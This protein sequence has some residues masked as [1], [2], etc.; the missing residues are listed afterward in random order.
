MK[1]FLLACVLTLLSFIGLA[2]DKSKIFGKWKVALIFD[3]N[4]FYDVNKD[5]IG[6][7]STAFPD[8][9]L[10]QMKGMLKQIFSTSYVEFREDMIY[11]ENSA[12]GEKKGVYTIDETAKV[13]TTILERKTPSGEIKRTED[14]INYIFRE[15][16][17]VFLNN[18]EGE[19]TV[20]F[21]KQ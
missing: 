14:K 2:Q 13:L 4:M 20:E 11:S 15:N 17:L 5:S 9:T 21:E 10:L 16:R 3:S 19:P 6:N 18:R 12:R 1:F 7:S 8:S